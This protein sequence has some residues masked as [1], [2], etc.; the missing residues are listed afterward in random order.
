MRNLLFLLSFFSAFQLLA[1]SCN[2]VT[3]TDYNPFCANTTYNFPNVTGTTAPD[4]PDYACLGT[5]PNPV[6]YYMKV[7][8][9]GTFLM[10]IAQTTG[11]NGTGT[12]IDVDYA[13]WGPYP[14]LQAGC[15][16]VNNGD[17]PAQSSYDPQD[18]EVVGIGLPGGDNTICNHGN[19]ATTPPAAV[20]G[21]YYVFCITNYAGVAGYITFNQSGGNGSA[22][23]SI[24]TPCDISSVSATPTSCN[25]SGQYDVSGSIS[26]TSP[27]ATG[28]LTITN[29]AGGT[30]TASAPFA[31][32][33][34]YSFT[35][36]SGTGATETITATFS[37]DATCTNSTTYTAPTCGCAVTAGNSGPVCPGASFDL[38]AS[39][40]AGA[41]SYAW[42]GP[43]SYSSG[44][45]NPTGVTAPATNGSYT[46]TVTVTSPSGT[47]TQST[48]LTVNPLP[49]TP[50]ISTVAPT[51]SADGAASISNYSPSN[52]YSFSPAGPAS[53]A[54][55]I[56]G[57]TTGTSYT[58]T[59]NDG[60]C[61]STA[62]APFSIA[63]QLITPAVPNISINAP[64]CSADGTASLTNYDGS[65]TYT[66][67]PGGPSVD[68]A[69]VISGMTVGTSYTLSSSNGSCT[70]TSSPFSIAAQLTVPV[71]PSISATSETCSADGSVTISNYA[72]ANTY[73]FSPSGPSVGAS[74]AV[75]GMVYGTSYTV[76]ATD[77]ICTSLAS[78]AFSI[79]QQLPV[80]VLTLVS[81]T[82]CS[83][84][85]V[86]LTSASVASSDIGTLSYYS[87]AALTTPVS[88]PSTA[89][90]G[91]YYVEAIS[92]TCSTSGSLTVTV[93]TT[94]TLTLNDQSVCSPSTVDLTSSA[95]ASTD[96]GAIAYY[97]DAALSTPVASPTSVG[98]GTYYLEAT[99][100][101]CSFSGVLNVSVTTTPTLTLVSQNTCSPN[102]IDLTNA[103][104][105][106]TDVGTLSYYSDAAL[107]TLVSNPAAVGN[108]TYYVEATNGACSSNGAITVTVTTTPTLT[109][110]D[111]AVCSPTLVDL[112]NPSVA[113]TDVGTMAYYSDAALTTP[114]S[115]PN[116]VGAGTYYLEAT[117]GSCSFSGVLNV[118]VTTTPTLT[119]ISQSTCTPYTV[120]LTSPSVTSTDIGSMA[121]YSDAALTNVLSN[122]TSITSGVYYV[123]A[124]NGA[125]S[126]NGSL[127]VTVTTSP[128]LTLA[129]QTVCA[130][131]T[132]DLTD[133]SVSSTDVG[134][135]AYYTDLALTTPV[136]TPTSVGT[137][138]YYVEATNG[139]CTF[140]GVVYVTVQNLPSI[141]SNSPSPA[142]GTY[143]LPAITGTDIVNESYYTGTNQTGTQY[144]VGEVVTSSITLY[145]FSG[146][147][148][149]S[150]E[151]PIVITVNPLPTVTAV[152]NG[153][154]YCQG[155]VI[156]PIE[157]V[158]TGSSSWTVDYALDG[159]PQSATGSISPVSLGNTAG[160]Y[161]LTSISD[162][163]C[164]GAASGTQTITINPLPL[165]PLT[166]SDTTYCSTWTLVDM[167][168][169][170]GSGVF[171]WYADATLTN[172]EGT[173]ATLVPNNT[174]GSVIYYVTETV[175]NCEGPASSV[176]ITINECEIVIPTAFT[177][178]GDM[179]NDFWEIVYLDDVY[180]E[181]QVSVYNR[182]GE[183]VY[184]SEKGNYAGKPWDGT[185][186]DKLLPVGSYFYILD[187]GD[188]SD[189]R[190]GTVSIIL[191]K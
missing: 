59:A 98:A 95:V 72:G 74:G 139:S 73:V 162:A 34:N 121:Y 26:F 168:A 169:S 78:V 36:I 5:Q 175:N 191:K 142:C 117:N 107:T 15:D 3:C 133:P 108:G 101:S 176:T 153:A 170:G 84:F 75:S 113:S 137:G 127:T 61:T 64:T 1:T 29:S 136:A 49:S 60:S 166:S 48:T 143:T 9:S 85:T 81:Q 39:N 17:A 104:V 2:N 125:C 99:N 171:T 67:S 102:T 11:P 68:A 155:D 69:G 71:T 116:A 25:G 13:M 120:D 148:G 70:A 172:V 135:L 185:F 32:P 174:S 76:T 112:T 173:G 6:W 38:S 43:S 63:A 33:Y 66:F 86:D 144:Q 41:T 14:D 152:N 154:V 22:D 57:M 123:E 83:P 122:P 189:K 24:V 82:I 35:G 96:V 146:S 119:L 164:S 16:G 151:E 187:P 55:T 28:T 58:V 109:L 134:T 92:S 163:N 54:G 19:G 87:D 30:V 46:Y 40:V 178:N 156:T 124:T 53:G 118:T 114:L 181:S 110:N 93:T 56:S 97:T 50:T 184:E 159:V 165:A 105:S 77:G 10:N 179:M 88:S 47:C 106:S 147:T 130:P 27:P 65:V 79:N 180:S 188:G 160:V 18:I 80:P 129:D 190:N 90:A 183:K 128:T 141:N 138:T 126:S 145:M 115:T 140:S 182:W 7:S 161:V 132:V 149:C 157:V 91:T 111:Q 45:Q 158:V 62:S 94:P 12:G 21:Q 150:D 103:S 42:S 177:P 52:T 51:C 23:C 89:G 4:C 31:S 37:D 8:Q 20:A 186:N 100:G 131:A 44:S 167:S